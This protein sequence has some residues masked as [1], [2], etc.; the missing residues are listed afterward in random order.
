MPELKLASEEE[1]VRR[2]LE[3]I[4][5]HAQFCRV[6]TGLDARFL[7]RTDLIVEL[8]DEALSKGA[9]ERVAYFEKILTKVGVLFSL[10]DDRV[11]ERVLAELQNMV[12]SCRMGVNANANLKRAEKEIL[13]RADKRVRTGKRYPR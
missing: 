4:R 1:Y 11:N 6:Y 7:E 12:T 9:S 13:D 5:S 3:D 10:Y 2:C 8:C